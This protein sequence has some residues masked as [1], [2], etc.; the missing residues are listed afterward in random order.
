MRICNAHI[1]NDLVHCAF[2][3]C[4]ELAAEVMFHDRPQHVIMRTIC[5]NAISSTSLTVRCRNGADTRLTEYDDIACIVVSI[6]L[7]RHLIISCFA[8]S[9]L[10]LLLMARLTIVQIKELFLFIIPLS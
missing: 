10:L 4:C 1:L 8:V 7:R 2:L 3:H 5:R 6:I 9:T